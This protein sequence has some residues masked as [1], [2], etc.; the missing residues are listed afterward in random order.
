MSPEATPGSLEIDNRRDHML[1]IVTIGGSRYVVDVGFGSNYVPTQPVR[2]ISDTAGFSNVDPA[3]ARLVFKAIDGS[4]NPYQKLWVYQHRI[5]ND[6]EFR[7]MYCFTDVEFRA[8]DF[9]M[10]NFWTSSS[11]KVIFTQKVICNKMILGGDGD[12]EIVGTLTLL[13]DLKRRIGTKSEQLQEFN[14][15]EQRTKALEEHFRIELTDVEKDSIKG[16][17]NEIR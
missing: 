6:S 11:P 14:C 16:T 12:Q 9:E 13:S 7:D 3:S 15:E 17:V 5:G 4:S 10:M 8:R 2:L 1:N